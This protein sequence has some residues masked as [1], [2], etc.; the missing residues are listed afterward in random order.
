LPTLHPGSINLYVSGNHFLFEQDLLGAPPTR[1]H[2][3]DV[4]GVAAFIM[5][6]QFPEPTFGPPGDHTVF[7]IVAP[8]KIDGGAVGATLSLAYEWP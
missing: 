6:T 3:C 7:E 8:T 2:P 5:R 1:C 4:N